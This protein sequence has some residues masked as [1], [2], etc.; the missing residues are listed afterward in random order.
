[1]AKKILFFLRTST[2][3]Q[4]YTQQISKLKAAASKDGYDC[5]DDNII[6]IGETESGRK[7]SA[8]ER[9]TINQL[10]EAIEVEDID[11]VYLFEISRLARRMDVLIS[12]RD[13]ILER[14]IQLVCLNPD[15]VLLKND[16]SGIRKDSRLVFSLFGA[17]A[18]DEG[19]M[20]SERVLKA[21]EKKAENGE[22]FGGSI[23]FGY[24]VGE[25]KRLD[26]KEDEVEIIKYIF[27]RYEEGVTQAKIAREL[28]VKFP[29]KRFLLSSV[30]RILNNELYT[31]KAREAGTQATNRWGE[32]Y[33][34]Y[35]YNRVYPQIITEEQYQRC[36]EIADK[37]RN[38]REPSKHLYYAHKILKCPVC[39]CYWGAGAQRN[40]YHCGN[41]YNTMRDISNYGKIHC[42]YKHSIGINLLDAMLWHI[43]STLEA[44]YILEDDKK[45]RIE[46]EKQISEVQ[47]QLTDVINDINGIDERRERIG[48]NYEDGVYTKQKRNEKLK[49]VDDDE[50]ELNRKK[51]EYERRIAQLTSL[52][53]GIETKDIIINDRMQQAI[54][55]SELGDLVSELRKTTTDD[56]LRYD[57]IHK[58]IMAVYVHYDNVELEIKPNERRMVKMEKIE[59]RRFNGNP[60]FYYF[61]PFY[62]RLFT[63]NPTENI[64][65]EIHIERLV[66]FP[67]I[68]RERRKEKA[69][70]ASERF[71][72]QFEGY[73]TPTQAAQILNI[74]MNKAY[75]LNA[76]YG[77]P[78]KHLGKFVVYEIA[79]IEE[80]KRRIDNKGSWTPQSIAQSLGINDYDV[81]NAIRNGKIT[82]TKI[83][84]RLYI[85]D[86]EYQ[87]FAK[88][89]KH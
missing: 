63:D 5:S 66:R 88:T 64:N 75:R 47:L 82:A 55:M 28:K 8:E 9:K 89:I 54:K 87:R 35:K 19:E 3:K 49:I 7:L 67:D 45:N 4:D 68:R 6:T 46:Y 78:V 38:Q 56:K 76:I 40:S 60:I 25:N 53:N 70:I 44:K 42:T 13:T 61:L 15:F 31:G 62:N 14:K 22:F 37:N 65:S 24:K 11:A 84:N 74:S 69:K 34:T 51:A 73:Y 36:R 20:L 48:E 21:F 32:A 41:A 17:L 10:K 72:A 80:L 81:W 23:P 57:I 85:T 43:G 83:A 86:E 18:E 33:R 50:K 71:K 2:L 26:Y 79:D 39:G 52:L 59:I 58:H 12:I 77:T 16:R 30:T 27:N 29:E 1:M